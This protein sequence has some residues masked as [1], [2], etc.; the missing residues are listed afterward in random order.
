MSAAART[1]R[2]FRA[3]LR[4][5]RAA[6]RGVKDWR[7][8]PV[9]PRFG[10][11]NLRVFLRS[12]RAAGRGAKKW[13]NRPSSRDSAARTC[14]CS[15]KPCRT[16]GVSSPCG[17]AHFDGSDPVFVDL[18]RNGP[19]DQFHRYD[20]P[21]ALP[22]PQKNTASTRKR[23]P[24]D[25]DVG[26]RRKISARLHGQPRTNHSS[27]ARNLLFRYWDRLL[28]DSEYPLY[29]RRSH[30]RHTLLDVEARE[31]IASEKRKSYLTR[32]IAPDSVRYVRR[33]K[34]FESLAVQNRCQGIRQ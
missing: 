26:S 24:L 33:M 7:N 22:I 9:K 8:P 14:A 17:I 10:G 18:N 3:F 27:Y 6:G 32:S 1:R 12:A 31:H 21:A 4:S 23:A 34:H 16:P 29:A 13:R 28:S 19:L 20:H 11:L 30:D 25:H 2:A 15:S 5:A